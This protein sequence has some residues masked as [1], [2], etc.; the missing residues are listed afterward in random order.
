MQKIMTAVLL[1]AA[2]AP[3][4]TV[5]AQD[6]TDVPL[7]L[8]PNDSSLTWAPCPPVFPGECQMT[9]VHG[10][11]S[12]PNADVMLRVAP[13]YVL[14]RHRHTSAERMVLLE[15]QLQV[16]YDGSDAVILSPSTY[17]FGPARLPHDGRCLSATACTLF[18]AFEGPVDAEAVP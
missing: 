7:A 12:V 8:R 4:I 10:D 15:G 9:V 3:S 2:A 18:I 6:A 14:P 11:P 5:M 16:K 1:G 13:G 17:A